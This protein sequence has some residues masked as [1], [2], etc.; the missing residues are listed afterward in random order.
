MFKGKNKFT[1][2]IPKPQNIVLLIIGNTTILLNKEITDTFS[3]NITDMGK[4]KSIH[5]NVVNIL[6]FK[7]FDLIPSKHFGKKS[8]P[9]TDA[10]EKR[11]PTSYIKKGL[12]KINTVIQRINMAPLL[13]S[14][15]SNRA[16]RES[17][18]ILDALTKEGERPENIEKPH[19]Q[20][21]LESSTPLPLIPLVSFSTPSATNATLYPD[22]ANNMGY[23]RSI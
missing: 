18:V 3:K 23:T 22:A 12:S 13:L 6:S 19:I 4:V 1:N 20:N 16:K 2:V 21:I 9:I 17:V 15:P 11:K 14:L 10:K 8:N 7:N 5:V